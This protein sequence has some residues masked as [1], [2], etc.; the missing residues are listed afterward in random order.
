MRLEDL[1]AITALKYAYF[2]HLDLKEFDQ[3]GELLT[4]TATAAYEDGT[5]SLEG[6]AAIVAFL[7]GS[8]SDPGIVSSH[9]GHHPEITFDDDDRARGT[10]YLQDRVIVPRHDLEIGGTA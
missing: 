9:H 5:T 8:L 1:D 4:E 7:S 3:L 6:R 10:W 2:R